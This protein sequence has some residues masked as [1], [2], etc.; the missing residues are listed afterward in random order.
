MNHCLGV[1]C[2]ADQIFSS[3]AD[4]FSFQ[5]MHLNEVSR[6]STRS[7][8]PA[9]TQHTIPSIKRNFKDL[10]KLVITGPVSQL[11]T[12]EASTYVI[13]TLPATN[14]SLSTELILS[15]ASV[16]TAKPMSQA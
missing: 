1:S 2:K 7:D 5:T 3:V 16:V 10:C 13:S 12:L 6:D 9:I 14:G 4:L 15:S 11:S 8:A